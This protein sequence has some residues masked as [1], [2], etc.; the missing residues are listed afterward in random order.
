MNIEKILSQMTLKEKIALCSGKDFWH[1][2]DMKRHGIPSIMMADGP[3]GLRCQQRKADMLGINRSLPATCFPT[4]VTSGATWNR[5]L[6]AAKGA[7]IAAEAQ[8]A[9]VSILLGPGCNIK[10]DPR[11]GRNFEYF[12]ED[13]YLSGEMAAA[14]IQ[15]VQQMGVAACVK[16]FAVNNQE[17]KRMNGDSLLDER[18]LREIY[19]APFE[20]AVKQGK[21][22]TVMCSYNKINGTHASDHRRLLHT[23]LRKEWGFDGAVITDW[24]AMNDRIAAFRAGCDLNMPG[25]SAYMER[26]VLKAVKDGALKESD[27]DRSARRILRLVKAHSGKAASVFDREA[28]HALALQVAEQ[29]AVLLKNE[30]HILPLQEEKAVLIGQMAEVPRYQGSGSSHI[31]PIKLVSVNAAMPLA[32][33]LPCGDAVGNVTAAELAAAARAA[34]EASVAVV[35]VGLPDCYESEGFDR[36][37]VRLPEGHCRLVEVVAAA[38]PNT[39]V[40][41]FGGG[42]MELPFADRVKAIL[43]MGLPGQAGGEAVARLL[44]GRATPCGRLTES[45]PFFGEDAVS[46]VTFG[47]KDTEYREGIYVGYRYYTKANKAVRYPFGYGLSYTSFAYSDLKIAGKT[48]QVTVE[49]TGAVAG[50]E[51]VQLYIAPPQDG[52][53]RPVRELKGFERLVLAPGERKTVTFVLKKRDFAIWQKGW[54]VPSGRYTVEIGASCTDI[55][56]KKRVTVLGEEITAPAWQ[57][58]SFYETAKGLPTHEEWLMLAEDLRLPKQEDAFTPDNTFLE[59]REGSAIAGALCRVIEKGVRTIYRGNQG[60]E[61]PTCRMMLSGALDCPLR[62]TVILTGG[63][64][65]EPMVKGFLRMAN[66]AREKKKAKSDKKKL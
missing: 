13:P 15:G 33:H 53:H 50:A 6:L 37:D 17:Y 43:Y 39:V 61:D 45:W 31:N 14:F 44:T 20:A 47:E 9:G 38:N 24:G 56:L 40:V 58:G 54:R 21:A 8:E 25:G 30:D 35:A 11:G 26:A 23:V 10:R 36:A 28:H 62:A 22:E 29:G 41:L 3:H 49:N 48:V 46:A 16:H 55:K 65:S 60:A 4:A 5:S 2:K 42:V 64:I 51:V 1:T 52:I 34:T 18:T 12:S 27:V 32:A 7:A 57:A 19:L 59:L 66:K 63:A